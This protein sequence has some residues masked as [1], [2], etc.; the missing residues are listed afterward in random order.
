MAWWSEDIL[1]GDEALDALAKIQSRIETI[2]GVSFCKGL[3]PIQDASDEELGIVQS[4]LERRWKDVR[5]A[6]DDN[7][8]VQV[9]SIVVMAAGANFT[10]LERKQAIRAAQNDPIA[11]SN[12]ERRRTMNRL[13]TAL[14]KYDN[15]QPFIWDALGLR[16]QLRRR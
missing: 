12:S 1:G 14:S 2:M 13:I 11:C 3:H 10:E 16:G 4:A 7:V 6:V 9:L 15:G 8:G 5:S